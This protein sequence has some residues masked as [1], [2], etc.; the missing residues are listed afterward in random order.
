MTSI[1]GM[2][3]HPNFQASIFRQRIEA[4][5]IKRWPYIA[6]RQYR[7]VMTVA[8]FYRTI[9][10]PALFCTGFSL[11]FQ[12]SFPVFHVDVII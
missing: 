10:K 4:F 3:S 11:S 8:V 9:T 1:I 2:E 12:F 5:D 6:D 7:L